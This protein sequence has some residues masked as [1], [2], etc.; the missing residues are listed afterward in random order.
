MLYF[1]IPF[2]IAVIGISIALYILS[3][4]DKSI[5]VH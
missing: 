3:K 5:N 2:I 1:L 4:D